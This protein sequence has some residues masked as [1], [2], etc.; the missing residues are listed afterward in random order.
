MLL[1]DFHMPPL[2]GILLKPSNF[3][4]FKNQVYIFIFYGLIWISL[5]L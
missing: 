4:G 1:A 5:K 2:L 3:Q